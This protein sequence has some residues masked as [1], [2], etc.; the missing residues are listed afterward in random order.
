MYAFFW[1]CCCMR[2]PCTVWRKPGKQVSHVSLSRC[3]S[4]QLHPI[5][6]MSLHSDPLG[7][8]ITCGSSDTSP[9]S[10]QDA[11]ALAVQAEQLP[12]GCRRLTYTGSPSTT[13]LGWCSTSVRMS[14]QG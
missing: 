7:T 9:F 4:V 12:D 14:F 1:S 11:A 8:Y 10:A 13:K 3:S 5:T 2:Q 6:P